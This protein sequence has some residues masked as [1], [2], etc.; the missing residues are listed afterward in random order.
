M[1]LKF[2]YKKKIKIYSNNII[3]L[4]KKDIVD[5]NEVEKEEIFWKYKIYN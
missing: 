1:L 4:I 5:E 3:I 2:I